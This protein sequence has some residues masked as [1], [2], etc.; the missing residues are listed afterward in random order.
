MMFTLEEIKRETGGKAVYKT[1]EPVYAAFVNVSGVSTDTRTIKEGEIFIALRGP[2][3]DGNN[4]TEKA[5]ECGAS[6]VLVDNAE[7]VPEGA[8]VGGNPARIIGS[9]EKV[10]QKRLEYSVAEQ[11]AERK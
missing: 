10:A 6:A 7:Y 1:K 8:V 3:F 9:Y 11:S 4:Y 2:N 5:I